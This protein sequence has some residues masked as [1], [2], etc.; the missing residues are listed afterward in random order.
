M[1]YKTKLI[2]FALITL[3]TGMA[4][5]LISNTYINKHDQ[6]FKLS[7]YEK[8][9][10]NN[11]QDSYD[12]TSSEK[13]S[14]E[15]GRSESGRLDSYYG[16]TKKKSKGNDSDSSSASYNNYSDEDNGPEKTNFKKSSTV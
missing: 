2:T 1:K 4:S 13:I 15:D 5:H 6:S 7:K 12:S 16:S 3:H 11:K 8:S 10:K 9:I 14:E